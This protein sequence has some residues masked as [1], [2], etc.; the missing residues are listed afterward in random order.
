MLESLHDGYGLAAS[1]DLFHG[2]DL[3]VLSLLTNLWD[4]VSGIVFL[5]S[6]NRPPSFSLHF[7]A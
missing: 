7:R 3:F 4:G 1:R 6:K 5:L 2:R